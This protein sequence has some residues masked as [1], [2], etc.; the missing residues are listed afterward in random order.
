LYAVFG[1]CFSFYV[2]DLFSRNWNTFSKRVV[3]SY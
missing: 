2:V 1:S 3:T